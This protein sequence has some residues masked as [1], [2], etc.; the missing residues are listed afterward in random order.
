MLYIE[1]MPT[2]QT[3]QF[4][5]TFKNLKGHTVTYMLRAIDAEDARRM[6][7]TICN[8]ARIISITTIPTVW[9]VK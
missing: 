2:N 6:A 5:V 4:A 7:N 3:T 9:N 1:T 8:P